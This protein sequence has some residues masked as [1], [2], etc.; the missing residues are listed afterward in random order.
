MISREL[1]G[2]RNHPYQEVLLLL[3]KKLDRNPLQ[4]QIPHTYLT[5]NRHKTNL[6]IVALLFEL[7]SREKYYDYYNFK[8]VKSNLLNFILNYLLSFHWW[9]FFHHS[10]ILQ[11]SLKFFVFVKP[12]SKNSS[13][14]SKTYHDFKE[15]QWRHSNPFAR[16]FA[17]SHSR[18]AS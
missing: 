2:N 15:I 1:Q 11:R 5:L 8:V 14:N 12:R 18:K 10:L 13:N 9:P 4:E 17:Q 3:S 16:I 7:Y 6:T